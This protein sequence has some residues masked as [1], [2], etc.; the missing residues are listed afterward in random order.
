MISSSILQDAYIN[1]YASMRNYIWNFDVI[2]ALAEFE[3][4]VYMTFPKIDVLK[5]KYNLLNSLV[6][7]SDVYN[8][9]NALQTAFKEMES[10]L[11]DT[12]AFYADLQS[13][14][15]VAVI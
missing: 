8:D 3:V 15:G 9:D 4:E 14:K 5:Q 12:D 6:V 7:Y 2:E 10:L 1:L 13:F 11:D